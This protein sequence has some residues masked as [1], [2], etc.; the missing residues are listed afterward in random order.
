ME[1]LLP[2]QARPVPAICTF[3]QVR[4]SHKAAADSASRFCICCLPLN[5]QTGSCWLL[6][7]AACCLT[8]VSHAGALAGV[9]AQSLHWRLLAG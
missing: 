1:L 3:A 6:P 9:Y 5:A 7:A 8:W 4:L 2:L